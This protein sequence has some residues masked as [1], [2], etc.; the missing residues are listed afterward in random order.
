MSTSS[1]QKF[2]IAS[3]DAPLIKKV[4]QINWEACFLCQSEENNSPIVSPFKSPQYDSDPKK[5]SYYKVTE[6]LQKVTCYQQLF[7][8]T[9]K[10]TKQ[11][12]F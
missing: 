7:K 2:E 10:T 3:P 12:K 9:L 4:A 11:I 1:K 8:Y 6:N 5:P